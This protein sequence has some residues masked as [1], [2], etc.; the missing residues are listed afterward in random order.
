MSM[1]QV[2]R[3][4]GTYVFLSFKINSSLSSWHI[5][6]MYIAYRV[7]SYLRISKGS[8]TAVS[9]PRN[10]IR[11]FRSATVRKLQLL[12]DQWELH[13]QK[14]NIINKKSISYIIHRYIHDNIINKKKHI[15]KQSS[16][17]IIRVQ[18][19][20]CNRRTWCDLWHRCNLVIVQVLYC[21]TWYFSL[22]QEPAESLKWALYRLQQK[23]L[24]Y[25]YKMWEVFTT[26]LTNL[27]RYVMVNWPFQLQIRCIIM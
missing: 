9:I 22:I 25:M 20:H 4:Y 14:V 8:V 27:H 12:K 7:S 10:A 21:Q 13:L 2:V 23:V 11:G 3:N 18:I 1:V 17:T 6:E 24:W 5:M 16:A 19:Y 15:W 26:Q